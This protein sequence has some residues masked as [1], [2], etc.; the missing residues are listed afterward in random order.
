MLMIKQYR[1]KLPDCLKN[2]YVFLLHRN[3]QITEKS[4]WY[5]SHSETIGSLQFFMF[6]CCLI[7]FSI[8]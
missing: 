1:K 4:V 3:C 2:G 5:I 6:K 7:Y 8:F